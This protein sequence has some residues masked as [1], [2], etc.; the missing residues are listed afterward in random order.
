MKSLNQSKYNKICDH[1]NRIK[2]LIIEVKV[3]VIWGWEKPLF[4]LSEKHVNKIFKI[5]L[6][7]Q[8]GQQ[9]EICK[10]H[11]LNVAIMRI[12]IYDIK[13]VLYT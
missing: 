13:K 11:L 2:T 4:K 12:Q 9:S 8:R 6:A 7:P 5:Q 10:D 1:F 3:N